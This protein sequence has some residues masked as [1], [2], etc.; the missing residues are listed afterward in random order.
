MIK[1]YEVLK[2]KKIYTI[3]LTFTHLVNL[4][5]NVIR[6]YLYFKYRLTNLNCGK[7]VMLNWNLDV[8]REI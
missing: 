6:F 4:N 2:L 1:T 3:K 8:H 5:I 7:I